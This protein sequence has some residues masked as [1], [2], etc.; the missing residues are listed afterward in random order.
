M[1]ISVKAIELKVR[2]AVHSMGIISWNVWHWYLLA[3]SNFAKSESRLTHS[4][5]TTTVIGSSGEQ[6]T[7]VVMLKSYG[8][9]CLKMFSR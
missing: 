3:V 7:T 2:Y 6:I 4:T 1:R 8:W 5:Q 9:K